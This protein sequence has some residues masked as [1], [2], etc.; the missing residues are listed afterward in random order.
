V[1]TLLCLYLVNRNRLWCVLALHS[2]LESRVT[3]LGEFSPIGWLFGQFLKIIPMTS[4][5]FWATFFHGKGHALI[6]TKNGLGYILGDFLKTHSVTLLESRA[7]GNSWL[8][9]N[10]LACLPST[11]FSDA[12]YDLWN[13]ADEHVCMYARMY[14]CM[15]VCMYVCYNVCLNVCLKICMKVCLYVPIYLCMYIC[16]KS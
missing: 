13:R 7:Q 1:T 10:F 8:E 3:R 6:L 9:A 14:A 16:I 5:H 12:C 15:F 11:R 4:P 2:K